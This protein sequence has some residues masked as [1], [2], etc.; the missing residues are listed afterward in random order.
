MMKWSDKESAGSPDISYMRDRAIS[1]VIPI[2]FILLITA[3]IILYIPTFKALLQM[4]WS[5]DDYSHGFFVPLISLYLVWVKRDQLRDIPANPDLKTGILLILIS[6]ALLNIGGAGGVAVLQELSIIIMIAG[7]IALLSGAAYLRK[8]ALPI[9]YLVFMIKIFGDGIEKFHWPFQLVAADIGV[10]LLRLF[11]YAAYQEANFIQLPWV[12]LEVAS[13]CSGVRFLVSII[14][15]GIPLAHLTQRTWFRK[16][17]LVLFAVIVAIIANGIRVALIGVWA[18]HKGDANIHGPFHVLYGVFVS[19]VGFIVL[20]AGAWLLR[21]GSKEDERPVSSGKSLKDIRFDL[22]SQ[23]NRWL[24]AAQGGKIRMPLFVAIV[25]LVAIGGYYYL[26]R[27]V[28]VPLNHGFTTFPMTIGVWQGEEVDPGTETLRLDWADEELMR[29]YRDKTGNAV[30]LYVGYFDDQ[31]Q[32]KE[33]VMYKTSWKFH[34]GET[35]VEI[36][37]V[38]GKGY[39]VNRVVLKEGNDNARAVH[40]WYDLNGRVVSNRYIAKLYTIWDAL[41]YGRTNG[42]I[43]AI[44]VPLGQSEPPEK[45]FD[46]EQRFIRETMLPIRS[47]LSDKSWMDVY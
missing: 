34:R 9:A 18:Y 25:L 46:D 44:S 4:W 6:G 16:T 47:Y 13:A 35:G 23:W 26:H 41:V 40:F 22:R 19:W 27:T 32:G 39:H 3:F 31:K 14:A 33:L 28:P 21:K 2:Q 8:L 5:S 29:I 37:G 11:G 10:W 12:T 20:F 45:V 1:R 43:V 7:L 17:G 38:D 15:I 30:K 24:E 36:S 42:A